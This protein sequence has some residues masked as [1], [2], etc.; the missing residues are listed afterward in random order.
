VIITSNRWNIAQPSP[1]VP[2][3]PPG[4]RVIK[5]FTALPE[6]A[7]QRTD[8]IDIVRQLFCPFRARNPPAFGTRGGAALCPGLVCFGPFGAKIPTFAN[9]AGQKSATQKGVGERTRMTSSL[10]LRIANNPG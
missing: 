3:D 6:G 10:T 1:L 4:G 9:L 5:C 2:R 7:K 8:P